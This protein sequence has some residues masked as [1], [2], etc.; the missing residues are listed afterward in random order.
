[1]MQR[2]LLANALFVNQETKLYKFTWV[3]TLPLD[4]RSWG[5]TFGSE[6]DDALL[7]MAALQVVGGFVVNVGSVKLSYV[8]CVPIGSKSIEGLGM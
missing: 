8:P 7:A 6:K 1:M 4:L 3:L 5:K 2:K